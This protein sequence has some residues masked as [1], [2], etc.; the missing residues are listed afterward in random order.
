[1]DDLRVPTVALA[2][3]VACSDGRRSRGEVFVPEQSPRHT[4]RMHVEEW[5]NEPTEFFPFRSEDG[6][7][8]LNKRQVVMITVENALPPVTEETDQS[9]PHRRV[10][11][12]CGGSIQVDGEVLIEI[13]RASCRERVYVLV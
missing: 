6:S 11:V 10:Q 13:G 1:M 12:D 8:L 2:V 3:E 7:A 9:L 4:G 5:V